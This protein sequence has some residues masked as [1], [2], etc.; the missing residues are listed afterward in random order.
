MDLIKFSIENKAVN[1]YCTDYS[2][3]PLVVFNDFGSNHQ[4]IYQNIKARYEH[5]LNLLC[6]SNIIWENDLSPWSNPPVVKNSPQFTGG[7]DQYL[8]ILVSKIIPHAL[9]LIKGSPERCIISGY[10]LAGLFAL[11]SL[12][13]TDRF[14]D[15]AC[16][17][18][19]LWFPEFLSYVKSHE[20]LRTPIQIYLSLGDKEAKTR[21]QFLKEVQAK[22][23]EITF[24]LQN[25][26]NKVTYELNPGNHFTDEINRITK[27]I[28]Y[29]LSNL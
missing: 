23:E 28:C 25:K 19:S 4:K 1:L 29:I 8:N 18:G 13:K 15:C 10:S 2:D 5:G 24:Y 27:G 17:S 16:I 9:T 14:T 6:I 11:Y 12:Y 21:N 3:A 26:G 22:T 20:F 7:A